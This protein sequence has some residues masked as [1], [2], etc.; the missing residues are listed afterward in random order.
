MAEKVAV[1]LGGTSAERDVSL[2]SG[3]AVLKGLQ[4]AGIDA[5]AVDIRDF[6]VTRLNEEG[7]DKA[8]IALH[9]RGGEDGTLQG[10]LELLDIPYTGSGVMASAIT[11]DKL[12]SKYLWQGCGLPVSP[13]IALNRVQMDAGLDAQMMTSINALGLPL[14]VKPS[15]EG[16][17]V[18][19]SRVNQTSELQAALVEAFRH[20]DE[21]LV[22][23]FLSGP[24]YTVGVLGSDI[25]PSIRIQTSSEFYDYDAKYISDETQYFCPS[26][27]SAD[28]E[29]ELRELTIAAWRAL[30]CSGWGRVDVMMGADG[31]F[32]LLEVNTSPGMTSHSL[33]PM[34]A[35]Q[36]GMTFSQLVV[37]ILE[38]AD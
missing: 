30:G 21:V 9:G 19:I 31:H 35:K 33:V 29:T 34:A 6:P 27:L 2:L 7:F 10:V 16:S 38:L 8:F 17:S 4:E 11:M 28:Q 24:E 25:L 32:Y 5:H 20:D 1:L 22:E 14:F 26:G 23:A 13:F 15:R 36:A 12:R 37:R 3:A 18:G